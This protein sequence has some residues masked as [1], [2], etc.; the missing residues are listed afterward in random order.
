MRQTLVLDLGP[1]ANVEAR[2]EIYIPQAQP[3]EN[4]IKN[5]QT[6]DFRKSSTTGIVCFVS[7]STKQ[8]QLCTQSNL[9]IVRQQR[10][11]G[12]YYASIRQIGCYHISLRRL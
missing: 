9:K 5:E 1:Y 3:Y 4:L 2:V 10:T 7:I 12:D 11:T 6:R 8:T